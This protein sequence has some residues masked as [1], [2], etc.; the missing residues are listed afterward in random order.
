MHA[1]AEDPGANQRD[2]IAPAVWIHAVT[3]GRWPIALICGASAPLPSAAVS[4]ISLRTAVVEDAEEIRAIYNHEVTATTSTFDLVPR[5]LADQQRWLE[6]RAGAF[7][8]IVAVDDAL[9]G[10]PIAGFASLSAYKDRAAYSTTVEDSVYVD[11]RAGG[12][13]V[14]TMLLT[15][16]IDV[17]RESGFHTVMAR[18]EAGGTASRA[19]HTKCGFELVGIERQ[20]GR[21]FNRWLD[22]AVMQRL[23]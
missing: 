10:S 1:R 16:L 4:R 8:A 20:V 14:G 11:R 17:A 15:R 22:V 12:R 19:L 3:W 5:S 13:G 7:A 9:P 21:K 2:S 6:A 18:I 23:L